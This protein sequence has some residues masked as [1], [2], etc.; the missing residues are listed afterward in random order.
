MAKVIPI[1]ATAG[2]GAVSLKDWRRRLDGRFRVDWTLKHLVDRGL[3]EIEGVILAR[4]DTPPTSSPA[5]AGQSEDEYL[6]EEGDD[7]E[8]T[9]VEVGT[10]SLTKACRYSGD[11]LLD[12]MDELSGDHEALASLVLE[13]D[14]YDERFEEW[15]QDAL[16]RF[17]TDDPL[18]LLDVCVEMEA[19]D[20]AAF[21]SL[22]IVDA[23]FSFGG[24]SSPLISY[25]EQTVAEDGRNQ[26]RARGLWDWVA[27]LDAEEL[28][29]RVYVAFRPEREA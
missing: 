17:P 15:C 12:A 11:D 2:P 14:D 21:V 8:P 16:G 6:D 27:P 18:F 25:A 10:V 24:P 4:V 28:D 22:A 19:S 7:Y 9:F 26:H 1:R 20:R 23:L 3:I 13:G 29:G 5:R